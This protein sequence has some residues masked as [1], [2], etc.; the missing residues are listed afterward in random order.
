MSILLL[1]LTFA[2]LIA[3]ASFYFSAFDQAAPWFPPEF[4][5]DSRVRIALDVLIWE[6]SFPAEA[7]RKYLLSIG[8]AAVAMLC[9]AILLQLQDQFVAAVCFACLFV[10]GVGCALV[11]WVKYKDRL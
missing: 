10:L 7:R 9:A 4:R 6:R 3:A 5:N 1:L 8:L 2:F 11:R